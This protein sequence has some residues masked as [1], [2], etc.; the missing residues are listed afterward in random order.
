LHRQNWQ[1][2]AIE[3]PNFWVI[4]AGAAPGIAQAAAEAPGR[5]AFV[6]YCMGQKGCA[7]RPGTYEN[8]R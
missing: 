7:A 5:H 8:P 1:R 6:R 3:D 4:P 2:E